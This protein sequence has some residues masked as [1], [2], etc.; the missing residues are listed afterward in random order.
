VCNDDLIEKY[1]FLVKTIKTDSV[2]LNNQQSKLKQ[3]LIER[4][5]STSTTTENKQLETT[6][7]SFKFCIPFDTCSTDFN[8]TILI[9][10]VAISLLV[11]CLYYHCH[12]YCT[13]KHYLDQERFQ[14]CQQY[15]CIEVSVHNK[16]F[17]I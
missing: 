4:N 8:R 2:D 1:L 16:A 14:N 13:V 10:L 3:W 5:R 12:E 7:S 9:I 17:S 6:S 15:R 11:C